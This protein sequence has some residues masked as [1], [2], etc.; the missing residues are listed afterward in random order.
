MTRGKKV[1]LAVAAVVLVAVVI[2]GALMLRSAGYDRAMENWQ[3][4]EYVKA[5]R[6]LYKLGDYRDAAQY[7][8]QLEAM[9]MKTLTATSWRSVEAVFDRG[10]YQATGIWKFVFRE[11]YTGTEDHIATDHSGTQV[12]AS[13]EFTYEFQCN[14][15]RMMIVLTYEAGQEAPYLLTLAEDGSLEVTKLH[16]AFQFYE[17]YEMVDYLPE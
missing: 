6:D 16:G 7:R 4:Q 3:A 11:D 12:I 15:G 1:F 9:L 10:G 5:A 17:V 2:V 14:A 13:D 8:Q